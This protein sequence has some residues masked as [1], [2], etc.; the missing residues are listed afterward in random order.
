M[1][2]TKIRGTN[3]KF[4]IG[5][6]EPFTVVVV[7]RTTTCLIRMENQ[8]FYG[9]THLLWL[10]AACRQQHKCCCCCR[11]C[12]RLCLCLKQF[13]FNLF[14][15]HFLVVVNICLNLVAINVLYNTV[16]NST[17]MWMWMCI[18]VYCLCHKGCIR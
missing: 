18:Y 16:T 6:N 3:F 10:R 13:F 8:K 5:F 12:Y 11:H 15:S 1:Q 9:H 17:R 4:L 2:N 7:I 14:F